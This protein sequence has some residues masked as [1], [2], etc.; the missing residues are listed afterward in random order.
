MREKQEGERASSMRAREIRDR[1]YRISD[2]SWT[3]LRFIVKR[4]KNI[5]GK[6]D[7][8][9]QESRGLKYVSQFSVTFA[10]APR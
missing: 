6:Q 10:P 8:R 4:G 7:I 5:C 1:T 9:G 2:M 3:I